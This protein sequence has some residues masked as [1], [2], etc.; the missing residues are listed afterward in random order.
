M[1]PRRGPRIS[2]LRSH[3][4]CDSSPP[5]W[6]AHGPSGRPSLLVWWSTCGGT[7]SAPASCPG[8]SSSL[9]A[10]YAEK[11]RVPSRPTPTSPPVPA[12]VG[13][14]LALNSSW[15]W[16]QVHP[17]QGS[18]SHPAAE[19]TG[20]PTHPCPR[21]PGPP[22]PE[23]ASAHHTNQSNIRHAPLEK[24]GSLGEAVRMGGECPC[25]D[26]QAPAPVARAALPPSDC[27]HHQT[28]RTRKLHHPAR[29][30]G[31]TCI[32]RKLGPRTVA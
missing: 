17:P 25:Q 6:P 9:G 31:Q 12:R 20:F 8:R 24:W 16:N 32:S 18:G 22:G 13:Q 1:T 28:L 15:F 5:A 29:A 23:P 7:C 2:R 4:S 27:H 30:G 14:V 11:P 26:A 10:W 19:G 21:A 3:A